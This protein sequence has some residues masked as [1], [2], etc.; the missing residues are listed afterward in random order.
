LM[1]DNLI[2]KC[3]YDNIY[4]TLKKSEIRQLKR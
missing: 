3:E 2:T 4:R 1:N